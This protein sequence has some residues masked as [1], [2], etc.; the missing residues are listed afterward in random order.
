MTQRPGDAPKQEQMVRVLD[1]SETL[2]TCY[3]C[4]GAIRW[5]LTVAGKRMPV[6]PEA[7]SKSLGKPVTDEVTG[8]SVWLI[9]ASLS[10]FPHC[11]RGG[12]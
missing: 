8:A 5:A 11:K 3:A 1:V 12:R 9:P 6:Q 7:L 2:H 4:K 10:H